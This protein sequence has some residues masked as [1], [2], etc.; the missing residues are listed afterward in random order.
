MNAPS[1]NF[2]GHRPNKL[3]GYDESTELNLWIKKSL[4]Q[5]VIWCYHNFG[6]TEWISGGALGID[7][8]AAEI[9]LYLKIITYKAVKLFLNPIFLK[10]LSRLI[11]IIIHRNFCSSKKKAKL[12]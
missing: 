11:M 8:W 10:R 7:Q 6:T 1:C 4:M 12:Y 3:G 9:V 5:S 2:T